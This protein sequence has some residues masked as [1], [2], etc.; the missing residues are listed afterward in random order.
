MHLEIFEIP[1]IPGYRRHSASNKSIA[2]SL[3]TTAYA[4]PIV[5]VNPYLAGGLFADYLVRGRFHPIPKHPRILGPGSLEALTGPAQPAQN[6]LSAGVQAPGT[7]GGDSAEPLADTA[8]HF[9]LREIKA[10]HE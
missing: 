7:A 8:V 1:Q 3:T 2:E 4:V 5:L 9:G 10:T 6:P